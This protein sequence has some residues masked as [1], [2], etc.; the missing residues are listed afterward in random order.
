MNRIVC[1]LLLAMSVSL[2]SLGCTLHF[3]IWMRAPNVAEQIAESNVAIITECGFGSGTLFKHRLYNQ[4]GEYED[5]RFVITAAH[6]VNPFKKVMVVKD[7]SEEPFKGTVLYTNEILDITILVL[8]TNCTLPTTTQFDTTEYHRIGTRVYQCG[9]PFGQHGHD[10][11]SDGIISYSC[12]HSQFGYV[13]QTTTSVYPGASGGSIRLTNG[14]YIGI[15]SMYMRPDFNYYIPI[16]VIKKDLAEHNLDWLIT[17]E[18][19]PSIEEFNEIL[20]ERI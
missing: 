19:E 3:I 8:P 13:D 9:S 14:S 15:V 10:S 16:R 7:T 18:K 5:V 11:I 4:A 20:K 12:R 1:S 17:Y 6:V 2:F